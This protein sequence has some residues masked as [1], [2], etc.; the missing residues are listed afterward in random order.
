MAS[1]NAA[2]PG[3]PSCGGERFAWL[4]PA[5]LI[6]AGVI[7][8][9]MNYFSG[10]ALWLDEAQ[11]AVSVYERSFGGLLRPL[12]YSQVAP[13][14]YL[15]SQKL[16]MFVLGANELA[17]RLPS[18]LAGILTLLLFWTVV[19]RV[20]SWRAAVLALA[21]MAVS[22][23]LIY[24]SGECKPYSTDAFFTVLLLWL[25]L[26]WE[27]RPLG[28]TVP[29]ALAAGVAVWC[30]LTSVF[31]LAG[32]GSV[33]CSTALWKRDKTRL[34]HLIA[35]Y[36]LSALS[37]LVLYGILLR[38]IRANP[39]TIAYLNNY[40]RHGFM[41]FPPTEL[42]Q[43]RWF[44]ERAFMFFD[45]PGGF[46]LTELAL[47][48]WLV[49]AVVLFTR[50]KR[51]FFL[52][53]MPLVFALLAS[54][55][56]VYPFHARATLFLAPLLFLLVGEG[57]GFLFGS[58]RGMALAVGI[59][60]TVLLIAQPVVRAAR[61]AIVPTRHHEFDRALEYVQENWQ[62][63]DLLFLRQVEGIAYLFMRDRVRLP[64]AAVLMEPRPSQRR[65]TLEAY[66][67]EVLPALKNA[68]RVWAPMTYDTETTIKPVVELLNQYGSGQEVFRARGVSLYAYSFRTPGK[69]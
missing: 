11:L 46:T 38:S 67:A 31:V 58:G 30:S 25:A 34:L 45:M 19:S 68:K 28:W 65:I 1:E 6:I 36:G 42:F 18:V 10:R 35:I 55:L 2:T 41:P 61:V 51:H 20:L 7:P 9:L 40:W 21:F 59:L 14:L 56:R 54:G 44:R 39:E 12:E 64:E 48:T 62:E 66:V 57:I 53:M 47:F 49:G 63:G 4:I 13:P 22:Q 32:L 29:F 52:V 15:C 50:N 3:K 69:P 27:E 43:L 16:A 23:H 24:Y 26:R 8:R 60:L 33:Q 17:V 37:F 5:A